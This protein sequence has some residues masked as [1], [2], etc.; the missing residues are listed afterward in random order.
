MPVSS[1]KGDSR[2]N[3]SSH[4]S[5][6]LLASAMPTVRDNTNANSG[7]KSQKTPSQTHRPNITPNKRRPMP[8]CKPEHQKSA[9]K[10]VQS[11]SQNPENQQKAWL[12]RI[13]KLQDDLEKLKSLQE[14]SEV[15]KRVNKIHITRNPNEK[16]WSSIK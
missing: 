10:N 7:Q 15:T 14:A 16:T 12:S 9:P 11:V 6:R 8:L 3:V 5:L 13:N 4:K 2:I 1:D